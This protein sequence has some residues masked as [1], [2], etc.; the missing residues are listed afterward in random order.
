[1]RFAPGLSSCRR[2]SGFTLI[3]LLVVIA[4]IAVL[5]ALLLPAVQSAR[6]AARRSQCINNLKQIGLALHNYESSVGAFPPAGQG[7]NFTASPPATTF[8]DGAGVFVR[9]LPYIEGGNVSNAYNFSL[10]YN[11]ISASNKTACATVIQS[12]ICPSSNRAG[13]GGVDMPDPA[14]ASLPPGLQMGYGFQDYGAPCYTDIDALGRT[15]GAGS[16]QVTP[17]RNNFDRADGL[18]KAGMTRLAEVTDGLTS[19]FLIAEDA[20][21]DS[22]Y[23]ANPETAYNPP[24]EPTRTRDIF[25]PAN[26]RRFWRWAE[27]DGAFGV[28]GRINNPWPKDAV[29]STPGSREPIHY[30]PLASP[31][32]N[33][34]GS[35]NDEIYS[36]HPGGANI[37]FGDG[38]VK[39][40]KETTNVLIVRQLVTPRG[41][42]AMS[43]DAY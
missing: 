3:E 41:G 15:G 33:N 2:R 27:G 37:L 34:N 42:E 32:R 16:T 36:F 19:T 31:S 5:I 11:H 6:E 7:T 21:R 39:F 25:G 8:I 43:S 35:N 10:D 40:V 23:I 24:T 12:Y 28:S 20:G 38:S 17:Y 29:G 13:R 4:I 30:P 14:E 18:L 22:R 9:I 1:M 26:P